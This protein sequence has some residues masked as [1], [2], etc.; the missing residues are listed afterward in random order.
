MIFC[1]RLVRLTGFLAAVLFGSSS[2]G[3]AADV[4]YQIKASYIFNM[5]Q[6]VEFPPRHGADAG[7]LN[8]CI[9]GEDRFGAAL[10]EI[11]GA[12]LAQGRVKVSR[13][14]H[15][16]DATDLSPCKVLYVVDSEHSVVET[17]LSAIDASGTLTMGES[18]SF[19]GSGG[20]IEFF[21][22]DDQI[23]F[24][25]NGKLINTTDFKVA[26]QLI[27]LGVVIK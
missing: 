22:Q 26:A 3:Y 15:Y 10:D 1:S 17:V 18:S 21:I 20:L 14:G 16:S 25:I 27:E 24:R 9:L 13:L 23:R 12:E 2:L 7:Q 8:V 6:F 11:D 4:T 5:L 19:V